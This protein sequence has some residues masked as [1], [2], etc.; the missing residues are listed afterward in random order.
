M[1]KM[2][3]TPVRSSNIQ[4]IGYDDDS[5][6]LEVEFNSGGIYQYSH[7]NKE[8]YLRLMKVSSK[9]TFFAENIKDNYDTKKVR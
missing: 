5:R 8:V 7:V 6:V 2:E 4:S 1:Y 3:R 9:G